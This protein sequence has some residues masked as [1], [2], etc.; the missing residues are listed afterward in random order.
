MARILVIDDHDTLREGMAV[1]LTAPA[2][3][4][5]PSARGADGLAAYKKAPFDLVVTDLKMDG[6]DGIEVAKALKAA[7]TPPPW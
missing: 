1:T 5:P 6:M 7:A 4:C 3:P 2:T